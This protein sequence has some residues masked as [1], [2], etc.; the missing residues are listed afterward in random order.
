[1]IRLQKAYEVNSTLFLFIGSHQ[2]TLLCANAG[3]IKVKKLLLD[4]EL[5][6][7]VLN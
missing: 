5:V 7:K 1:M 6:E 3:K 4:L 2:L